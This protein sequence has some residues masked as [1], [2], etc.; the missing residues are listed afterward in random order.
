MQRH[1]GRYQALQPGTAPSGMHRGEP[2]YARQ[3]LHDLHTAGWQPHPPCVCQ[4]LCF[5]VCPMLEEMH[6]CQLGSSYSL[7]R[8]EVPHHHVRQLVYGSLLAVEGG[9]RDSETE[10][11][12][13]ISTSSQKRLLCLNG[14]SW[15][16]QEQ[17]NNVSFVLIDVPISPFCDAEGTSVLACISQASICL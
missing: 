7:Q 3:S 11:N 10:K 16:M 2:F 1:I 12:R 15:L 8:P 6:A 5:H 17:P 14:V 13:L 9:A 4:S